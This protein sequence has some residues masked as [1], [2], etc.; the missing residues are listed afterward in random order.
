MYVSVSGISVPVAVVIDGDGV[1]TRE[2]AR[3]VQ[4]AARG[5][6]RVMGNIRHVREDAG[7]IASA[8]P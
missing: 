2:I 7:Q 5:T 1:A 3:N 6:E 8:A 4:E